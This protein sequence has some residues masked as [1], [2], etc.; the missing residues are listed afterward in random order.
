MTDTTH[1]CNK[2]KLILPLDQFKFKR[3]GNIYKN[4][5]L[6]LEHSNRQRRKCEHNRQPNQ[7]KDCGGASICEH[8]RIRN[9]CKDCGGASV[10]SHNIR[11]RECKHCADPVKVTIRGMMRS[12]RAS[13]KKYDRYDA[14]NH[15]DYCFIEGLIEDQSDVGTDRV[16][17]DYPDCRAEMQFVEFNSTLCTI[18]RINNNLGHIK[19]NC[20]LCCRTCNL[21]RKS[22]AT[23][24]QN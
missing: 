1:R 8:N 21:S 6:C 23:T 2:C 24:P 17:C 14:N 10:C 19:S 9:Q 5:N 13:D 7:C 3:T 11:R 4:C 18:E 16:R 22:R 15:I 12:S 20:I